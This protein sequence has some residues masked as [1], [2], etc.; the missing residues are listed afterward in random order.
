MFT[1]ENIFLISCFIVLLLIAFVLSKV[2]SSLKTQT[3]AAEL[4]EAHEEINLHKNVFLFFAFLAI[5]I[6]ICYNV[7]VKTGTQAHVMEWLNLIVRWAH[8]TFGIAWI[9]ASFYFIFLENSLN[10]TYKLRD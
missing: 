9:G 1:A 3:D 8:V 2:T 7:V 5:I 6:F 4:E 10:R